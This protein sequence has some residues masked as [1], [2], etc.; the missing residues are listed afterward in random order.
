MLSSDNFHLLNDLCFLKISKEGTKVPKKNSRNSFPPTIRDR[1][2]T[3]L[4][5]RDKFLLLVC[6]KITFKDSLNFKYTSVGMGLF[7]PGLGIIKKYNAAKD[8]RMH[9]F[10]LDGNC[11]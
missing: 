7:H 11:R 8:N 6:K 2:D 5:V 1:N 10:R 3:F 4:K 9:N